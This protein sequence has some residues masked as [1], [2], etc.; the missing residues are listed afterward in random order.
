MKTI[1]L[2][3]FILLFATAEKAQNTFSINDKTCYYAD[4]IKH[5]NIA[6]LPF[7]QDSIIKSIRI[8]FEYWQYVKCNEG[9]ETLIYIHFASYK[10]NGKQF[11][12]VENRVLYYDLKGKQIQ[13]TSSG[14]SIKELG[15]NNSLY[16]FMQY[17]SGA[18]FQA[19][20][21]CSSIFNASYFIH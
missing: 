11:Q 17:F 8:P 2:S 7:K 12:L 9:K 13:I 21:Y 6:Q 14:S 20:A 4:S 19:R 16:F 1:L 15:L 3:S 10:Y 18:R 5:K